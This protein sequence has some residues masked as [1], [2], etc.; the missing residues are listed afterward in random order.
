MSQLL[1]RHGERL[2]RLIRRNLPLWID[3]FGDPMAEAQAL[4]VRRNE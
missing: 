4:A 1:M 2:L 3:L